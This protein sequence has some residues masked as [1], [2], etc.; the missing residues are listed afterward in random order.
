MHGRIA[1]LQAAGA[2]I[3]GMGRWP[4]KK[5]PAAAEEKMGR[6]GEDARA[7]SFKGFMSCVRNGEPIALMLFQVC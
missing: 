1:M 7:G 4:R 3:M 6:F 5:V 2:R